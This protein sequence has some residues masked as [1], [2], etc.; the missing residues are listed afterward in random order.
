MICFFSN[1]ILRI[2]VVGLIASLCAA[3]AQNIAYRTR[4]APS[5]GLCVGTPNACPNESWQLLASPSSEE[6]LTV[7]SNAVHL[8]FIEFDDQ[9]ALHGPEL[10]DELISRIRELDEDHP[11]LIVVFAHGWK[12][13]ASASDPNVADF[14]KFLQRIAVEDERMC[15][16]QACADRRVVGVYLG[17]R[18]LSASVEPFKELSF[19]ARKS[20]AHRVG[21][22]GAM[23]VLADLKKI[24]AGNE[25]GRLVLIGHSFGGALLFTAV[26]QQLMRD[27]A[28]LK[29]GS[30]AREAADLIV[31]VNPAFEA[32]RF[33][34]LHRRVGNMLHSNTQRPILAV[35]TSRN[36]TATRSAFPIG[37]SLGTLFESHTTDEQR[38]ENRTALGHYSPFQ[39][40]DLN[41]ISSAPDRR[42]RHLRLTGYNAYGCAWQNFQSG[43]TDTW[44]L[45]ELELSRR[46]ALQN[47]AQRRNP[48]INVSVDAGVIGGH[49]DIWGEDFSQFL[50]RF[51]A[52]QS[53]RPKETCE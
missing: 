31:L 9:G 25:Q 13:N 21:T 49:N 1:A 14:A 23:E 52:V 34:A 19:W 10:K 12:H 48:F 42:R 11:L 38:R 6:F 15:A 2:A 41:L 26:Q 4:T 16:D 35:F 17:W 8:G 36:D 20:R 53:W 32:S 43:A 29:R 33:R 28:F 37:R 3:C 27:T 30:V 24:D 39:T 50:Y 22:D 47:D 44:S 18:G 7:P 5:D 46:P 40:H 45:G 51:I